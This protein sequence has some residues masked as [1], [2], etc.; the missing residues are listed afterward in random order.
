LGHKDVTSIPE[1]AWVLVKETKHLKNCRNPDFKK[2]TISSPKL[3]K[4]NLEA[5]LKVEILNWKS[6]GKHIII[7]KGYFS[8]NDIITHKEMNHHNKS[9]FGILPNK[10]LGTSQVNNYRNIANYKLGGTLEDLNIDNTDLDNS[11]INNTSKLGE[12]KGTVF[13]ID[14]FDKKGKFRGKLF[15][16]NFEISKYHS[17][18]DFFKSGLNL[19]TAFIID[20]TG[21][22]GEYED[23]RSLH[24]TKSGLNQY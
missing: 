4:E 20:F 11:M 22:N 13:E 15:L 3:C 14:T 21:S 19:S 10:G 6:N 12:E 5:K 18:I 2:F 23:A 8:I 24:Y 1:K 9:G 7:S 17:V 16:K